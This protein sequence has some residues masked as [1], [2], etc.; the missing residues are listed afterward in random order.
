MS[1]RAPASPG[2]P[3]GR[4]L[5]QGY[6]LPSRLAPATRRYHERMYDLP[7]PK[8]DRDTMRAVAA[9]YRRERRAGRLDEP[10]R[11]AAIAAFRARH[12][13]LARLAASEAAG[14]IIAW[15]A[16]EHS[17]WFWNGVGLPERP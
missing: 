2:G 5:P 11:E 3:P 4:S 13:E 8:Y 17:A 16:R 12:P 9:A 14:Q 7:E 15:A 6:S 1:Q 10:A